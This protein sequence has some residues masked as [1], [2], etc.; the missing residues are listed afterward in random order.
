MIYSTWLDRPLSVAGRVLVRTEKGAAARLVDFS[1]PVCIMPNVAIHMNRNANKDTN[2]NPAVD[3]Q[4]LYGLKGRAGTMRERVAALAGVK[5]EDILGTDLYVYN[6]QKGVEW[7]DFVTAPRLDDL[8][9]VFSTLEAFLSS[10]TAASV[11]VMA[12]FDNEEVGSHTK[13]GAASTFLRDTL[14]RINAALGGAAEDMRRAVAA[15]L[16]L[17]CDNAHSVHPNHPEYA[18]SMN[19]PIMNGGIVIKFNAAQRYTSDGVSTALFRLI[20]SQAGVPVQT[21][22]NRPDIPGGGTLGNISASQVSLDAVDIGLAQLAMHS[23]CETA[24]AE[25]TEYMIKAVR[26]FFEKTLV[27][28]ENGEYELR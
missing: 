24:G 19:K 21:Y 7:S 6:P 8:Q 20:C 17:S 18:D 16:M 15:S 27:P 28:G 23:S 25:D 5:S 12:V 22:A 4:P 14:E 3:L 13:Q 9:C 2:Y 10:G 11:P 26:L 1:E